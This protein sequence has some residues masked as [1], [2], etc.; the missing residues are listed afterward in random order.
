MIQYG[1]NAYNKMRKRCWRQGKMYRRE[2][3]RDVR[4]REKMEMRKTL[5]GYGDP[6]MMQ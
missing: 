5:G 2:S 1:N 3:V 4:H 6:A